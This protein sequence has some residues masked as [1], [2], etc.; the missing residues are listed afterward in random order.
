MFAF[1]RRSHM[2]RLR[3]LV[4]LSFLSCGL[5]FGQNY[6]V[7]WNFGGAP[8][9][10]AYPVSNLVSDSSGNLYGTTK[11]GGSST[12]TPC[13]SQGGCGTVFEL[14]PNV[15]GSWTESVLY[16]FC[17]D[18]SQG[19]CLDGNAPAAGLTLDRAGNLY[20]TTFGGGPHNCSS[21]FNGCG[22]AF[23]LS[24]P[25]APGGGWI[26]SVLY[27]FCSNSEGNTCLDG[28]EPLSQLTF[29]ELGNLYGTTLSG[30]TGA[31]YGGTIFE[32]SPGVG[33]WTETVLYNF[34]ANGTDRHCSAG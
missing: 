19:F 11:L 4:V 28:A 20:G 8:N 7:L 13:V 3:I 34:C 18:F 26:E 10:G 14:S 25:S 22:T 2:Q 16:N 27:S 33:A 15:N 23:E 17:S 24:P 12:Q 6:K 29:D 21:G 30:G 1:D 5:A 32:L 31:W 9:D